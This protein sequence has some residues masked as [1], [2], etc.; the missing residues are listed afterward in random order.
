MTKPTS[1]HIQLPISLFLSRI[2][3]VRQSSA[4]S[5]TVWVATTISS[6]ICTLAAQGL[7]I[8]SLLATFFD[9]AFRQRSF[10]TH[11]QVGLASSHSSSHRVC[12][13]TPEAIT[14]VATSTCNS[15]C[16]ALLSKSSHSRETCDTFTFTFTFSSTQPSMFTSTPWK[17]ALHFSSMRSRHSC[18]H[19]NVIDSNSLICCVIVFNSV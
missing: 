15:L 9:F 10:N 5:S 19:S 18:H 13:A 6:L 1:T 7:H 4:A 3:S 8:T 2:S 12:S 14:V 17:I 16:L 11:L